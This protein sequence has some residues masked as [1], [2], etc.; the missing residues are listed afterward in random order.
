MQGFCGTD[1]IEV[2]RIKEAILN[3]EGFKEKVY[4]QKEIEVGDKKSETIRYQ[5]YAG[6]FAAKEAVYKALSR[7]YGDKI[8]FLDVEILNDKNCKERPIVNILNKEVLQDVEI[9]KLY[10]DVSI[11][12]LKEYATANAYITIKMD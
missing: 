2:E 11:S 4:T 6:R 8:V 12:H 9:G 10:I 1:I 3:T 5:Y 7:E